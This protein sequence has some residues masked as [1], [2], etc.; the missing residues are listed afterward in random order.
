MASRTL[1]L[2][3]GALA[4]LGAVAANAQ[5]VTVEQLGCIPLEGNSVVRAKIGG[6]EGGYTARLYFRRLHNLVEDFYYVPMRPSGG[7]DW[8]SV[9]PKPEDRKLPEKRLEPKAGEPPPDY[10]WA[11]W[12]KAKEAADDRDPNGDLDDDVI[13]ERASAYLQMKKDPAWRLTRDWMAQLSDQDLQQWLE[14]IEDENEPAEYFVAVFNSYDKPVAHSAMRVVPVRRDCDVRLTEV[15]IGQ[16]RNLTV[17][18]TAPW[19]QG[20]PVFHWLCD[21]IVTRIND[22]G[23]LRADEFCRAC[24]VAWADKVNILVPAASILGVTTILITEEKNPSP[25]L[26]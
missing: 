3:I 19:Q 9:L 16:A 22:L 6:A 1:K 26:P 25:T 17:G 13:R 12:W 7:A 14:S 15:E 11:A 4:L 21:G 23:I 2:G 5:P 18:E 20:E 8:W 10:P 24:V